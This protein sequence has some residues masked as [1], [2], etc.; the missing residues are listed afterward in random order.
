MELAKLL[1]GKK[2]SGGTT[3]LVI[4][5]VMVIVI[6][7]AILIVIVIVI[8]IVQAPMPTFR[9]NHLSNT[10]CLTHVFFKR[11]E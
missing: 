6:F 9:G 8:V 7:M 2:E 4:D 5:Q 10:T 3:C 1:H 11:G